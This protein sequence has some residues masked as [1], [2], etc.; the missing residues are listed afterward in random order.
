MRDGSVPPGRLARLARLAQMGTE[1]TAG[2]LVSRDPA[3]A[4]ARAAE[5][6]GT[7]RGLAAK[8]GQMASYVDGLIPEGYESATEDALR[9]LRASASHS[10]V[11]EIRAT[12]ESELGAP[13]GQLFAT[14]EDEP[15]ASASIGQV[16]RATL[17]DGRR[18]AVKVQHPGI[19]RAMESDL[20]NGAI[21]A[22]LVGTLAPDALEAD[23]LYEEISRHF[24]DELDYRIEGGWQERFARAF[25]HD[26][27]VVVPHVIAN[28][29]RRRVLTSELMEGVSLEVAMQKPE[30][31]RRRLA[32]TLWRFVYRSILVEGWF[33]ADPHPGNYLFRDDGRVVFL[34]FGCVQQL[35]EHVRSHSHAAHCAADARDDA[36]FSAHAAALVEARGG[37]YQDAFVRYLRRAVEPVFAS[38]FRITRSY[39]REL[40]TGLNDLRQQAFAKKS[41]FV[42]IP[43][44]T[45]LLNRLQ[46]GFFSVLARL[47]V[48]VDYA[49]VE[50]TFLVAP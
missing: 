36:L 22:R 49:A 14:W 30:A 35:S 46:I 50:R 37:P 21:L 20:S 45:V 28:R 41:G 39:A 47:D 23:R 40:V 11:A 13:L 17:A 5:A 24:R 29:S 27:D 18:V 9:A 7:L 19:D 3:R 25:A 16:H 34:D 12:V 6:L 44:S 38:P 43:E 10:P 32:E 1:A 26:G 33:N 2:L 8:V 42:P 15:F 48:E 31:E 4:A